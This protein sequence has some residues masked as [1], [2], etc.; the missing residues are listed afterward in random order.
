MDRREYDFYFP[1]P[2]PY[3]RSL[4]NMGVDPRRSGERF[5][6][7][8]DAEGLAREFAKFEDLYDSNYQAYHWLYHTGYGSMLFNMLMDVI[9][10]N[11]FEHTAGYS[12]NQAA[13]NAIKHVRMMD[14]LNK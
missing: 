3:E 8:L 11:G 7:N 10:K 13:D 9:E 1:T 12:L 5:Y 4:Y 2:L 14:K 6:K